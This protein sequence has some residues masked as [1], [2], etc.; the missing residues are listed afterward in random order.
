LPI[1]RSWGESDTPGWENDMNDPKETSA[2]KAFF[3]E[4]NAHFASRKSLL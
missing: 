1:V 2:L 3:A 4:Q